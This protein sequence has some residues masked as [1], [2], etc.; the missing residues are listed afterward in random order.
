MFENITRY[1]FMRYLPSAASVFCVTCVAR[2]DV[3][4]V[5]LPFMCP[6]GMYY[7]SM[8]LV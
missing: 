4:V 5:L 8:L 6:I 2:T 7:V 3:G 1:V